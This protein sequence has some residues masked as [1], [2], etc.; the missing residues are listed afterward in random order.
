MSR[1]TGAEQVAEHARRVERVYSALARVYDA[2]FDWA[3]GPGRHVA[4]SRLELPDGARV[5]EVGVGT[6]LSLPLY[7]PRWRVTGIDISDAM[8]DQARARL[9]DL[10]RDNVDLRRMDARELAF[11]DGN[12]DA[13]VAP[14][15]M[16]VVP[17][18]DRVMAEMARVC[19]PGGTVIVVN[20][21]GHRFRVVRLAE[22][23]L[24]PL[25]HWI[26]F[27]LDLPIE[28]VKDTRGLRVVHEE[29]VNLA[30]WWRLL[31]MRRDG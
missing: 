9:A 3:L 2:F 26:G 24:S 12:F 16:S 14:Y 28:T 23:L 31:V 30:G 17:D 1:S 11:P 15:V 22:T 25:T 29:T 10:G 4:V 7:S 18:P 6:G 8:L 21:F 27:R 20:H 5:L 13:V 19:R